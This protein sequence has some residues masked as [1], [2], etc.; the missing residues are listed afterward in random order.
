MF[1]ALITKALSIPTEAED[2]DVCPAEP[3]CRDWAEPVKNA[4]TL[5]VSCPKIRTP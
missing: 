5:I 1:E 3:P 2:L 4:R